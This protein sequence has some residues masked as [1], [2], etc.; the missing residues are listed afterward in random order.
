MDETSQVLVAIGRL[1]AQMIDLKD[2]VSDST[3]R[4][5][6][7]SEKN[8]ARIHDINNELHKHFIEDASR[9][10]IQHAELFPEMQK[11]LEQHDRALWLASGMASV[12]T[13]LVVFVVDK[14][15]K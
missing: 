15:I 10:C 12:I 13:G 8:R 11:K 5:T 3:T 9:P 1:E 4:L 14:L 7:A 2:I 6:E